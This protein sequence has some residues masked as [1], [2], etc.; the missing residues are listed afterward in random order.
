M[1]VTDHEPVDWGIRDGIG[2]MEL[3]NTPR[4]LSVEHQIPLIQNFVQYLLDNNSRWPALRQPHAD[5]RG[6]PLITERKGGDYKG[7]PRL[8]GPQDPLRV[9]RSRFNAERFPAAA[10]LNRWADS[11]PFGTPSTRSIPP[12]QILRRHVH[13][14]RLHEPVRTCSRG[15]GGADPPGLLAGLQPVVL[16]EQRLR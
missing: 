13:V 6:A 1:K 12:Y 8:A 10:L 11:P 16:P 9:Q 15:L 4:D 7:S 14:R 2:T 3:G 5:R